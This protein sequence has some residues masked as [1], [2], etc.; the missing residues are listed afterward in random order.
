M[1]DTDYLV[2]LLGYALAVCNQWLLFGAALMKWSWFPAS[3]THSHPM[4][5]PAYLNATTYRSGPV[6]QCVWS[7]RE[8]LYI[9][10]SSP[11]CSVRPMCIYG[12]TVQFVW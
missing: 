7:G 11:I 12:L 9:W 1:V 4:A 3:Y 2:S 8:L 6:I 5:V 10:P